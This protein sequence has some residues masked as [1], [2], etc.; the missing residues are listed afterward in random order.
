MSK[1]I[2]GIDPG[3][4]RVGIGI[5]LLNGNSYKHIFSDTIETSKNDS[6][7][8]RLNQIYDDLNNL[9][10]I[11]KPTVAGIE[12]LFYFKNS[13]TVIEV[14]EARGVILLLLNKKNIKVKEY[15]PLEIKKALT[16][17]G[18]ANKD[19]VAFMV[20]S[21]LSLKT[22]TAL[23]DTSDALAAAIT[24]GNDNDSLETR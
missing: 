17:Y 8:L 10:E 7:V 9:I 24:A 16:G 13:K 19:Q 1:V 12:K 18:S 6:L 21:I 11:Y 5:V 20:N 2:L 4:A 14:A 3:F 22:K 15:T 23:D